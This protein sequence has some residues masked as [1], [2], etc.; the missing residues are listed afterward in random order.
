[1]IEVADR[2]V[3]KAPDSV[4]VTLTIPPLAF[5]SYQQIKGFASSRCWLF[6]R[7][8]NRSVNRWTA[9]AMSPLSGR[10][11]TCGHCIEG[12]CHAESGVSWHLGCKRPIEAIAFAADES[13]KELVRFTR[14]MM[15]R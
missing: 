12:E 13:Q 11:S 14:R 1:M 4:K 8:L 3:R 10:C 5:W 9:Q 6:L 7:W 2:P 15:M